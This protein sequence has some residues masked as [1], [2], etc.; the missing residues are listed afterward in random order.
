MRFWVAKAE[1]LVPALFSSVFVRHAIGVVKRAFRVHLDLSTQQ[2]AKVCRRSWQNRKCVT[3]LFAEGNG[4]SHAQLAA[5]H[6]RVDGLGAREAYIVD[7]GS[8]AQYADY[9]E[10]RTHENVNP[11]GFFV[12]EKRIL[13]WW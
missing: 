11:H 4:G 10:H 1:K 7:A 2:F 8:Y 12:F 9:K 3:G 5:G 13:A 6:G